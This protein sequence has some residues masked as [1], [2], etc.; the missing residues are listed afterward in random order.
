M[1]NS[2]DY[3][4]L[5]QGDLRTSITHHRSGEVVVTDAPVDNNGKGESFSPT[6]LVCSALASCVMTILGIKARDMGYENVEM[7]ADVWKTMATNPR[8]IGKI[9]VALEVRIEGLTDQQRTILERTT[10]A[11]PVAHSLSSGTEKEMTF[12]W[13]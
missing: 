4:L 9:R 5:Y 2:A 12:D 3:S 6:D 1:N 13:L 7:K 8:R 11:C 10:R